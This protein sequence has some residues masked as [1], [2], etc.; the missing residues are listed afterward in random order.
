MVHV[1]DE[2]TFDAPLEKIWRFLNDDNSHKHSSLKFSKVL[3]QTDKG[4]TSE[5]EVKNP[6]GSWRKETWKL[7]FNPPKGF[8]MEMVS[9][10]MKGTK[11]S[12][13]YTAMGNKT[14]VVVEG[15]FVA[16]GMDDASLKKAA[17]GM[18]EQVFNEDSAAL[19]NYK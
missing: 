11:H 18:F 19:K 6:D 1:S 17:L 14:K 12:H 7:T 2:G 4:M 15:E 3:E 9:G 16:Q 8:S 13:T 10:P 5:V